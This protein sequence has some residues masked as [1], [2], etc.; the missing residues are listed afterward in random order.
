MH[1]KPEVQFEL[2]KA[3]AKMNHKLRSTMVDFDKLVKNYPKLKVYGDE[4][5]RRK[6]HQEYLDK[7]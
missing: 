3:M 1:N 7:K 6:K 5:I 4:I 2:R